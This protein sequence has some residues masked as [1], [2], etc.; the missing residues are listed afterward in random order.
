MDRMVA[1]VS[2]RIWKVQLR[3]V[4]QWGHETHGVL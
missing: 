1:F 4:T 3:D 2:L